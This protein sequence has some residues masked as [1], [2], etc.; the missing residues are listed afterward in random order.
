MKKLNLKLG[1][2]PFKKLS[3]KMSPYYDT[4]NRISVLLEAIWAILINFIIE[5]FS[6]HSV[7]AA[8]KYLVKTP[9]VFFYNAF[10]IFVTFTFVHLVRRRVFARIMVS[11]LWLLIGLSNGIML[12]KR[13]TPF[14]AQD[15]KTF[16]EG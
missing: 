1:K 6:R 3:E 12:M 5:A 11:A 7:V 9:E 15:L 13:V 16:K 10:M 14:N 2:G 8:W 4:L